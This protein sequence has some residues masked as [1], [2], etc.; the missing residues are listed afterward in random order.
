PAPLH[1]Q[2]P[3]R[4]PSPRARA[5]AGGRDQGGTLRVRQGRRAAGLRAA[6]ILAAP[7]GG[8]RADRP[9]VRVRLWRRRGGRR[10]P[11]RGGAAGDGTRRARRG[12][13]PGRRPCPP[14]VPPTPAIAGV[15]P[16]G[17]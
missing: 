1:G 16:R 9:A 13:R 4:G 7:R 11:A 15:P 17:P 10:P 3:V 5:P 6:S 8:P 2:A 12:G 14:P